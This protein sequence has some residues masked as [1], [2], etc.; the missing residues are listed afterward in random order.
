[1]VVQS[2]LASGSPTRSVPL[3]LSW[4]DGQKQSA[5]LAVTYVAQSGG[6]ADG[7]SQSGGAAV[8]GS[9][10]SPAKTVATLLART[11]LNLPLIAG[12]GLIGVAG[13]VITLAV[14][15]LRRRRAS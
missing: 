15:F 8:G 5:T 13:G 9:K 7:T 10:A 3:V 11:G 6:V 14:S 4:S 1:M 12:I 2:A